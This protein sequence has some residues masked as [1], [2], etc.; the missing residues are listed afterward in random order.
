MILPVAF[1]PGVLPFSLPFL[2]PRSGRF[3]LSNYT[4]SLVDIEALVTPYPDCV[5]HPGQVP[6]DFKLRLN[7]T[8]TI[9]TPPGSDVCWRRLGPAPSGIAEGSVPAGRWSRA[10]TSVGRTIDDQL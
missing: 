7:D 10:F 4:F 2:G 9:P 8:W 5:V 6:M 1:R 3:I